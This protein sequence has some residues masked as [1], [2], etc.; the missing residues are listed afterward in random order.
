MAFWNKKKNDIDED[1]LLSIA[2]A[3]QEPLE[4]LGYQVEFKR[5]RKGLGI[6]LYKR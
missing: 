2:V 3:V 1:E 5:T 4:K 6:S